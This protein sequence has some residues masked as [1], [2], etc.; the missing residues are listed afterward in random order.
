FAVIYFRRRLFMRIGTLALAPVAACLALAA[1]LAAGAPVG[2]GA[3]GPTPHAKP[4]PAIDGKGAFATGKYRDLF[5]EDGH[6]EAE[7]DAKLNKAFDQ[8]FHGDRNT[9]TL[10]YENGKNAD[11][12]MAYIEDF[13]NH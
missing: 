5:E 9:Q 1:C 3:P 6:T 7:V 8:L 12:P 4:D 11:G 10:Y 13:N 2:A